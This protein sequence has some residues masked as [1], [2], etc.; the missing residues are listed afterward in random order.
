ME[1]R[2]RRDGVNRRSDSHEEF[3][4]DVFN[5]RKNNSWEKLWDHLQFITFTL[6]AFCLIKSGTKVFVLVL[7]YRFTS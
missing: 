3:S 6:Y 1:K 7:S 2:K 5:N 4:I